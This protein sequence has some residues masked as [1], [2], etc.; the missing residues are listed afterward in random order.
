[1]VFD[2]YFNMQDSSSEFSY[3]KVKLSFN[4]FMEYI[5]TGINRI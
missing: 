5:I 4:S 3:E 1:M 2:A